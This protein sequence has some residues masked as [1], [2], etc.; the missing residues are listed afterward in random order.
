MSQV[1]MHPTTAVSIDLTNYTHLTE[2]SYP[3]TIA[4]IRK[5]QYFWQALASKKGSNTRVYVVVMKRRGPVPPQL[6]FRS[7]SAGSATKPYTINLGTATDYQ[8]FDV[9]SSVVDDLGNMYKI[10]G[11]DPSGTLTI[12]GKPSPAM[13]ALWTGNQ[14]TRG[15]GSTLRVFP[16]GGVPLR[17]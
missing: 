13:S 12:S 1:W 15:R 8:L 16:A 3:T 5:R 10:I 11:V 6:V 2:Y 17:N 4:D 7:A 14:D 9:G